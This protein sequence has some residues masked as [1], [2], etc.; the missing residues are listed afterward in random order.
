MFAIPWHGHTLV[1]TT[2]T[3]ITEITPDPVPFEE[4]IAFILETAGRYLCKSPGRG[5]ILSAWAGI[6]PLVKAGDAR[7][8]ASLSRDHSIH[9]D[10]NGLLTIAGGKWTTYRHMAE[11]CVNQAALLA[12]LDERD[13][14]TKRLRLHGSHHHAGR[15]GHLQVYG[16]DALL[17]QDLVRTNP[18]LGQ[19]LHPELPYIEAEVLWAARFEMARTVEDVLSRRT[20][21][22]LLN[23]RAASEAAPR[24]AELL[25]CELD[26]PPAWATDQV[27]RFRRLAA[28]YLPPGSA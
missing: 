22:L 18:E 14:V 5:D 15:F 7:S 10:P 17:L 3:P 16:S 23:A 8:T 1:G 4:E 28:A 26:R 27:N 11:D 24:V 21:A 2:D 12:G 13:C 6:R 20:R 19:P 25:A 9:I